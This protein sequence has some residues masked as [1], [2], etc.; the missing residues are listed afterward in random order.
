MPTPWT[1][2]DTGSTLDFRGPG[3][4]RL[5]YHPAARLPHFHPVVTPAGRCVSLAVPQDHPW[6]VGLYFAW[7][8]VN[9]VNCWEPEGGGAQAGPAAAE[10]CAAGGADGVALRQRLTW[11]DPSAPSLR[12]ERHIRLATVDTD[13][14]RLDWDAHFTA[15]RETTLDRTPPPPEVA[16]GGY[17]GLSARLPRSFYDAEVCDAEGRTGAAAVHGHRAAWCACAGK[18]DGEVGAWCG[19][20]LL[21]HPGNPGFPGHSFALTGGALQF[22]QRAAL[23]AAPVH[24]GE[25]DD[26]HLRYRVLVF[27]GRADTGRISAEAGAFGRGACTPAP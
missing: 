10:G 22:L 3:A 27:D 5:L 19:V 20:A 4:S 6:H 23:W 12:E 7:K 8:F 11:G 21:E 18:V 25:G 9:G 15:L 16:W 26:L 2:T 13:C 14:V 24:L 1:V 17:A